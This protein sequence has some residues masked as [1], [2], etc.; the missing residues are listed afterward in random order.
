MLRDV[1][2]ATL[3]LLRF[4]NHYLCMTQTAYAKLCRP[5]DNELRYNRFRE[6]IS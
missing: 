5:I 6:M 1:N 2:E 4:L 3:N